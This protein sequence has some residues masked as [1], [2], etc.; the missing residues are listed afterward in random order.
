MLLTFNLKLAFSLFCVV[1]ALLLL[2]YL[3]TL[4]KDK[5]HSQLFSHLLH[6]LTAM[7][8]DMGGKI[9][10]IRAPSVTAKS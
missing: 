4:L 8:N 5:C 3:V 1:C 2:E 7:N 10:Y 9:F 6:Y